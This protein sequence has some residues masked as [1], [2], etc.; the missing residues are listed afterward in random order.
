[1]TDRQSTP[2]PGPQP[3]HESTESNESNDD[4]TAQATQ[5]I[6][7]PDPTLT[8][9]QPVHSAEPT[10]TLPRPGWA[11]EP[12]MAMPQPTAATEP[13]PA[14][15]EPIPATEPT[16]ATQDP[17]WSTAQAAARAKVEAE[18]AREAAEMAQ[19][20]ADRSRWKAEDAAAQP[21]YMRKRVALPSAVIAAFAFIMITTGGN[22]SGLFR[23]VTHAAAPSAQRVPKAPPASAIMGQSVRDGKFAF[24]VTGMPKPAKSFTDRFGVKQS[25]QGIFV[26]VRI[27]V[28]N[29]GY[30]ARSLDPTDLFL[31]DNQGKRFATSSA[32][33]T[34]GGAETIFLHKV[35]PGTTVNNAPVVFDV[36]PGTVLASIELHDSMTSRGV[37]VK[38]P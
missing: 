29:I 22:D 26:I 11:A 7:S 30:D 24:M 27:R 3:G 32:I 1:M 36:A 21:W 34:F 13:T 9:Q 37:Q 5:V 16:P 2:S 12:T 15:Q 23:A 17:T 20:I 25:A 6:R 10:M 28:S 4:A 33:L 31:V 14:T 38:L 35:N 18:K 19:T 8:I